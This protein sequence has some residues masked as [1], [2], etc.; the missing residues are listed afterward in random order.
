MADTFG[1]SDNIYISEPQTPART[2]A[3]PI[4]IN[5]NHPAD[6]RLQELISASLAE[7]TKRAYMADLAHFLG[8]VGEL[9]ASPDSVALYLSRFAGELAVSTLTRR[10]A[11]LGKVHKAN[12]WENPCQSELVKSVS[13]AFNGRTVENKIRPSPYAAMTCS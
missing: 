8:A 4:A 1:T 13:V 5:C 6:A 2:N 7:N 10:V 12:G 9:P 11:T 3:S